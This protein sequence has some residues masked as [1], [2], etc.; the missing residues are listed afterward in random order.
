MAEL[1]AAQV[2]CPVCEDPIPVPVK[3]DRFTRT[4]EDGRKVV[5]CR[6]RPDMDEMHLHLYGHDQIEVRM[7]R[8]NP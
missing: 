5:Q 8:P 6:L 7:N 3:I 2:P 1:A 4:S